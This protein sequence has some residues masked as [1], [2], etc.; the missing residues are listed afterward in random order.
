MV[1]STRWAQ[2]REDLVSLR[3]AL[4]AHRESGFPSALERERLH[5]EFLR[6]RAECS[7][8]GFVTGALR[9]DEEPGTPPDDGP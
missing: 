7:R 4:R 2:L 5:I 3:L 9:D 1:G 8:L 6:L